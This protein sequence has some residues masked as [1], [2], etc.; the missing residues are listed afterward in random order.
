[1]VGATG[2]SSAILPEPLLWESI[3][4]VSACHQANDAANSAV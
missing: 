3:G 4:N 1:M 2:S